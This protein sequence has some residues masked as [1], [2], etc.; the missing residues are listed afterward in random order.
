MIVPNSY[1]HCTSGLGM[2]HITSCCTVTYP[3]GTQKLLQGNSVQ[4][5]ML[6]RPNNNEVCAM[7]RQNSSLCNSKQLG[8]CH[9]TYTRKAAL[10]VT[11]DCSSL[12]EEVSRCTMMLPAQFVWSLTET[13]KAA[14]SD[15]RL[16]QPGEA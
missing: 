10:S 16:Q 1:Q 15:N 14:Q 13:K 7:R 4:Q 12:L 5:A 9:C 11:T 6:I 3:T 2:H 8:I